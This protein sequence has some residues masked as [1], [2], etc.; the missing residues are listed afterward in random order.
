MTFAYVKLVPEFCNT[1]MKTK[2]HKFQNESQRTFF[3]NIPI[4]IFSSNHVTKRFG[5]DKR[6][7]NQNPVPF[8]MDHNA[9]T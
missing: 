8:K 4:P 7:I 9:T 3:K 2:S 6:T 1:L 5:L